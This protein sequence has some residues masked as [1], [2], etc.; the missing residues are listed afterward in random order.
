MKPVSASGPSRREADRTVS[1]PAA[2]S[3][4]IRFEAEGQAVLFGFEAT[5]M[6]CVV[7]RR[8]KAW[9]VGGAA[10][11]FGGFAVISP[12]VAIFPPHAVWLI[13]SLITGAVLARRRLAERFTLVEASG[14]CPKCGQRYS[15]KSGR[16]HVPHS[17]PC[18][19]CHHESTLRLPEG[20]LEQYA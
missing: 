15:I 5:P 2:A 12:F 3:T 6:N 1:E 11:R 19:G 13:G 8:T 16:L 18:D 20:L 7:L 14:D 10:Q 9:R 4:E 17:L